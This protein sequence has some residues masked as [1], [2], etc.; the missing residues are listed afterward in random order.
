LT[1]VGLVLRSC[2]VRR[3]PRRST[4]KTTLL[5]R[6]LSEHHGRRIAVIE[7]ELGEMP[8]DQV[9]LRH[10]SAPMATLAGGCL[11]CQVKGALAPV[12]KNLWFAS[13]SVYIKKTDK[14]R[15]FFR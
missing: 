15:I 10:H 7:N 12:L 5:N 14:A 6:I 1:P 4:G 8:V 9:L 13:Q 3:F 2:Y 11:C